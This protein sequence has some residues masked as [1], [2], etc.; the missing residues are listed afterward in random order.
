MRGSGKAASNS[1]IFLRK[2]CRPLRETSRAVRSAS[3][4]QSAPAPDDRPGLLTGQNQV[5]GGPA[6]NHLPPA[7]VVRRPVVNHGADGDRR[8]FQAS[9]PG[10]AGASL[11]KPGCPAARPSRDAAEP[12]EVSASSPSLPTAECS[13]LVLLQLFVVVCDSAGVAR[14]EHSV[15]RPSRSP[16][17]GLA[18]VTAGAST[19]RCSVVALLA[20][21]PGRPT[22]NRWNRLDPRVP[23]CQAR[24]FPPTKPI[25]KKKR[26][27][28]RPLTLCA[29]A[30]Q[31]N[32]LKPGTVTNR[33]GFAV[34]R[35]T[36]AI[37][38]G[39]KWRSAVAPHFGL[40]R[41]VVADDSVV[42]RT[43]RNAPPPFFGAV[44]AWK[45]TE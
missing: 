21:G 20:G 5:G 32:G 4:R 11:S 42:S 25:R 43:A 18:L 24:A 6:H 29:A 1:P 38:P 23:A 31:F 34:F 22:P 10:H 39:G 33:T 12:P 45:C 36:S 2:P 30:P 8:L 13:G 14:L 40:D 17:T 26:Y 41:A 27:A 16:R 3:R 44:T 9:R 19:T 35:R 7:V 28:R 37:A 15:C